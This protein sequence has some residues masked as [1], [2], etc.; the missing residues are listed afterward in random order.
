M[1][2][3]TIDQPERR[4]NYND[5]S[6]LYEKRPELWHGLRVLMN[7]A[8]LNGHTLLRHDKGRYPINQEVAFDE[9]GRRLTI[10]ENMALRGLSTQPVKSAQTRRTRRRIDM[11]AVLAA[12]LLL[13]AAPAF[14]QPPIVNATQSFAWNYPDT[15][16][17]SGSVVRFELQIDGSGWA[18][19]E[20]VLDPNR[21]ESYMTPIPALTSGPHTYEIRACNTVLCGGPSVPPFDFV[22]GAV[23][24]AVDGTTLR[25]IPTP[26]G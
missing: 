4:T 8:G 24:D 17:A 26:G 3:I 23:P 7:R 18:D 19:V 15:S 5:L 22:F 16:V 10:Y 11:R 21:A 2:T 12:V 13:A 14:A 6:V 25:I 20:M 1:P 9:N